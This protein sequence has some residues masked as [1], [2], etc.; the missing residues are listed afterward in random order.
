MYNNLTQLGLGTST[1]ASYG[2]SLSL[3]D[4]KKLFD[5]AFDHNIRTIDTSD[6][7]G[8]GDTERLIGKVIKNKRNNSFIISKV[9]VPY[10]SLPAILSPLNQIGKKCLQVLKI[11]KCYKKEYILEGIEKSLKRLN[12][13]NLDAYLLHDMQLND[14]Y[15]YKD[16]CFEALYQIKRK[17]LSNL[18]GISSDNFGLLKDV[19]KNVDLDLIQINMLFEKE[20]HLLLDNLKSS[21]YKLI[22]NS[23]FS[24]KIN[25]NL[26][27]KINQ[28]IEKFN[29]PKED[30][31][32]IL[33]NYCI[34]QR[35]ID[36]ALF[37][38]TNINHLIMIGE[39]LLKYKNNFS[40]LFKEIDN[41]F[42]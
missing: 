15:T 30:K 7:Y 41:L 4:A 28:V 16:E 17:G 11:K 27:I 42:L 36:C 29:I 33:I 25:N 22:V 3:N 31:K 24:K 8:S 34:F 5:T 12:I 23:I 38:T 19:I 18:V 32:K 40:K 39:S 6:T 37:R 14:F 9:G 21:K 20:R 1:L 2:R 35:K 26:D 13:E 10:L